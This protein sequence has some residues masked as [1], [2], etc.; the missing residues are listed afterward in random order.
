MA[1]EATLTRVLRDEFG[2][3]ERTLASPDADSI[4]NLHV[5]LERLYGYLIH[6]HDNNLAPNVVKV[7]ILQ[8]VRQLIN[9]LGSVYDMLQNEATSSTPSLV[10]NNGKGR[11]RYDLPVE[12][13]VYFVE[14]GFTC[15]KISDMLGISLRTVRRRMSEYGI[16]IRQMYSNLSDHELKLL[17]TEAHESFPNAGYRLIQGWL[18]KRGFRIQEHRVRIMIREIDPVGVTN[19]FFRSIHR[20]SYSVAGSQA[21]WHIDGNHK[22][23]R[24]HIQ[25]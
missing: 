10:P 12:Q 15:S 18:V 7:E 22:L 2:R 11:P 6:I 16:S 25:W 8:A 23:I 17:I 5:R 1:N 20:R 13:L 14:H 21:L 9:C 19:R 4:E 3:T 24:S